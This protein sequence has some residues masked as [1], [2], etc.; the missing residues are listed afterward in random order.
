MLGWRLGE[1]GYGSV[2]YESASVREQLALRTCCCA[3]RD[4][5]ACVTLHRGGLVSEGL[6]VARL[7]L[8]DGVPIVLTQVRVTVT[9][10]CVCGGVVCVCVGGVRLQLHAWSTHVCAARG[11][12]KV[13]VVLAAVSCTADTKQGPTCDAATPHQHH[14][15]PPPRRRARRWLPSRRARGRPPPRACR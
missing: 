9:T 13:S 2:M 11:S 6:E 4:P 15:L 3:E 8:S 5:R 1:R 12:D 14:Q 10:A 7:F